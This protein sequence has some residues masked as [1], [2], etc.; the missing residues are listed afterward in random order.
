MTNRKS[1]I[2]AAGIF[3]FLGVALGAFG[4]HWLK[5]V[6]TYQMMEVYQTGI[7]YHLIHTAVLLAISTH[8][9]KL[10]LASVFFGLGIILFSFSLYIYAITGIHALVFITPLGG[11]SFLAGWILVIYSAL[12]TET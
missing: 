9:N 12:R 10:S 3:G 8:S 5:E 4:A 1:I 11:M 7:L 2:V 6:I